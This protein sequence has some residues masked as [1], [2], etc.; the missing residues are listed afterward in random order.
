MLA[1]LKCPVN[2]AQSVLDNTVV[3]WTLTAWSFVKYCVV[4]VRFIDRKS[5]FVAP[6]GYRENVFRV[7]VGGIGSYNLAVNKQ[8][9]GGVEKQDAGAIF[10]SFTGKRNRPQVCGI[11]DGPGNIGLGSQRRQEVQQ[12]YGN[13]ADFHGIEF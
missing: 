10:I 6:D 7:A 11:P 2:T 8:R 4:F 5:L 1:G 9:A 13:K 3:R 12:N